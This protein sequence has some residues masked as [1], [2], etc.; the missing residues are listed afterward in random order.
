MRSL[1]IVALKTLEVGCLPGEK[2]RQ[3]RCYCDPIQRVPKHFH[4]IDHN[5]LDFMSPSCV[6]ETIAFYN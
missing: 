4:Y 1:I 3:E 5:F 2:K 6:V